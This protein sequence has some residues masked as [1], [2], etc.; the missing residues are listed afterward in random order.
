VPVE[1][2]AAGQN[3]GALFDRALHLIFE[4]LKD[5]GS[6]QR[7]DLCPFVHR[8][9]DDELFHA[10][11]EAPLEFRGD[12]LVDDEAFRGDAGL[13]VV[14]AAR[15]DGVFA[16]ASR[17]AEGMTM[18]GSLPPSSRTVFPS[19]VGAAGDIAAGG[20]AASERIALMR[21]SLMTPAPDRSQ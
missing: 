20:L 10:G 2:T 9:A 13:A 7:A 17:S 6:C 19:V 4:V 8:V 12:V 5:V 15:G 18:K 11:D 16:A 3:A 1:T 21:G 14:D